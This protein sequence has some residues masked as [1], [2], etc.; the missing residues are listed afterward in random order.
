VQ[1]QPI[2]TLSGALV[3][4]SEVGVATVPTAAS[5]QLLLQGLAASS[6]IG[7]GRHRRGWRHSI[8]VNIDA[9]DQARRTVAAAE[10]RLLLEA[11]RR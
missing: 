4:A 1:S 3:G 11:A 5:G 8:S 7:A 9:I 2:T 6:G 10:K